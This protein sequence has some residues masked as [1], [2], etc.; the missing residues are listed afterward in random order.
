MPGVGRYVKM[1]AKPG[2]GDALAQQM[3]DVADSVRETPGCLG[4]VGHPSA[5]GYWP[6]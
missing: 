5:P 1:H 4:G 2:Q 3:L 6:R